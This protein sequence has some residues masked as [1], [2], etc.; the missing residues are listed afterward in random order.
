MRA[1]TFAI[2]VSLGLSATPAWAD[3]D[4]YYCVGRDYIAYQFGFAPPPVAR[5]RLYIISLGGAAGIGEPAFVELPQFQVHGLLCN[6]R[7]VQLAGWDAIY[8]VRLDSTLR[9]VRYEI[10]AWADRQHTPPQFIGHQQNLGGWSRPVGTGAVE[11]VLVTKNPAGHEFLLE[12]TPKA[13]T[14]ERC[15]VEVT[16]R[17]L[18]LSATGQ[19][20]GERLVFRG[21]GYRECGGE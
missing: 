5:H 15:V 7:T 11:R 8:T 14:S 20:V 12:I 2:M 18:E 19:T 6:E 3:S 16:T 1:C 17:V 4:G 13:S 9:P 21:R 10:A